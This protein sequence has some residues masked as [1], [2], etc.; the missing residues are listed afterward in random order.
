[1]R[2]IR[3]TMR[4]IGLAVLTSRRLTYAGGW[5]ANRQVGNMLTFHKTTE[6]RRVTSPFEF[7]GAAP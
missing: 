3:R 4:K 2:R 5:I 1:M 6:G 7:L